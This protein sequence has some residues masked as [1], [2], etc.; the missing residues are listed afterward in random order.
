MLTLVFDYT[1]KFDAD[2]AA[3]A[4]PCTAAPPREAARQS[5]P[6]TLASRRGTLIHTAMKSRPATSC[7]PVTCS[8]R[9][10]TA[11]RP[12]AAARSSQRAAQPRTV[13]WPQCA[14][15]PRTAA[16][17]RRAAARRA[18]RPLATPSPAPRRVGCRRRACP[19]GWWRHAFCR[20][21]ESCHAVRCGRRR[22]WRR[23]D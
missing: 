7:R 6:A 4:Q 5:R 16:R 22:R 13:A 14:T 8:R 23:C 17:P 15:R 3:A 10:C 18:A 19:D 12:G 1:C 9:P 20:V 11:A 21:V 2:L